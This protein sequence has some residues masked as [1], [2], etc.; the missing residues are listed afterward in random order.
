MSAKEY[1]EQ[2]SSTKLKQ[3]NFITTSQASL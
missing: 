2:S 3:Q 1:L